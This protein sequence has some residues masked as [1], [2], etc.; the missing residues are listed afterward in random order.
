MGGTFVGTD[1]PA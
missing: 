1:R